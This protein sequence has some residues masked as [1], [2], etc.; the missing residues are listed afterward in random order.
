MSSPRTAL[1]SSFVLV[2]LV[3]APAV[4]QDWVAAE[5]GILENHV[6]LTSGERFRKAGECYFSPDGK[7][8]IFQAIEKEEDPALEELFYQM[9]VANL[10]TEGG[11][12]T[13]I[14]RVVRLSPKGSSNT[15]G[16][17]HPT[18]PG[19]AI[20]GC[21]IVPPSNPGRTG[22]Q[23][24]SSRYSW[25]FPAEMDI[26]RCE[27]AKADGTAATLERVVADPE[28]YLAECVVS[29]DGRYM[30]FC[31]HKVDEGGTG[32]DLLVL[33]LA[34][35]RRI[36]V[37]VGEGYDG[38]PFFSPDGKR[39]CYRSDRRGD[40]LL[41]I[42]VSE[43]EFD[44]TGNLLGVAREFQLTD[45]V[46]VNW[47]P[48]WHPNGRYLVYATSEMG[49]DNYEVFVVDADPGTAGGPTK[50]GT[51]RRRVTH[52]AKFDGLPVFD[53]PGRRMMW[54][55]QRSADQTSQVWI[56]DFVMPLDRAKGGDAVAEASHESKNAKPEQLQ[57]QD[58]DTGLYY[59]YDLS[60]H[61]LSVYD[62]E[63]H[64][65]REAV[66]EEIARAMKLFEQDS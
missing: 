41:Q 48:Y 38:G 24:E 29:A 44:R 6:Q 54:T 66:G 59:L 5:K 35:G 25:Q 15:C 4:A 27:I 47:A 31:E 39:L 46:H 62:P 56:A 30:V 26:V 7:Q 19:V 1:L 58:P 40:D 8:I 53:A 13:G 12:V 55:S 32:G 16:W 9:Y 52:A 51:R 36:N 17:F 10:V 34:T 49:H 42:F 57:V 33:E 63:T 20:F 3:A 43:L 22:Y 14:D 37:A 65:V 2:S 50:Y 11:R 28:A 45:N 18:E 21:T 64:T 61:E 23:R 60:T